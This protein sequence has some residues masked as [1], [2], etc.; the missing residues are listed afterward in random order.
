MVSAVII[1]HN[2]CELLG[3]A[4]ESVLNQTY[5]D[6]ELIVVS[7]GSTDGTD[8][9]MKQYSENPIVRY[10]S[11]KPGRGG[12]YARN[13]GIINSKGDYV[14]F[15]DDDDEW[16]SNKIEKQCS[17]LDNNPEVGLVY[18]AVKSIYVNE[19]LSYNFY[20][21]YVGDLSKTILF[22][23]CIGTTS[24][25]MVR[26]ELLLGDMFD[27]KLRALQDFEL[28]IR[29]CQRTK[30]AACQDV[31]LL[32][33][34]QTA[35]K[36]ITSNTTIFEESIDY[37]TNK[38]SN[39]LDKLDAEEQKE[40]FVSRKLEYAQRCIRNGQTSKARNLAVEALKCKITKSALVFYL[41][42]FFSMEFILRIRCLLSN[43]QI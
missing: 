34:N 31:L 5:R 8:D 10:V 3:R 1:T 33:Y 14:A 32:Y 24:S 9:L 23:N 6:I 36:Q 35:K 42:S 18:T 17:I 13:Q 26:K 40:L 39:L 15:L 2:R 28:W 16:V 29:L 25:V 30:V 7:D 43:K 4:I 22:G 38:H 21:K 37:I 20:P 19:K 27:E 41:S 11:Y 12:N